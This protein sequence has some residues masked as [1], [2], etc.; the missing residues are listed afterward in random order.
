VLAATRPTARADNEIAS[1]IFASR[2]KSISVSAGSVCAWSVI[3][4]AGDAAVP[5]AKRAVDL[6]ISEQF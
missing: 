5:A 3:Y 2:P 4:L 1:F 6:R